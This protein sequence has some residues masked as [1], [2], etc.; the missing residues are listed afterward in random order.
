MGTQ[1]MHR[2]DQCVVVV[3][4]VV[5]VVACVKGKRSHAVGGVWAADEVA[6][7]VHY[8]GGDAG[9]LVRVVEQ[10]TDLVYIE[11]PEVGRKVTSGET[12]GEIESVK[13]VSD[14]YSPVTGEVVEVN[15]TLADNLETFSEDPYG[16]GWVMKVKV[17][18]ETGVDQLLDEAAYAK[19]CA[20]EA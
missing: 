20:E 11:L 2:E 1:R 14:L 19:Q 10:L 6:A 15:S 18:D 7:A 9:H 16:A 13:A 12:F 5:V 4:V 17:T 8:D 3:V